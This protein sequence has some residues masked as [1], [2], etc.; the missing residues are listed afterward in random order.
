ML[1]WRRRIASIS[2]LVLATG[3]LSAAGFAVASPA[4]AVTCSGNGCNGVDPHASGCDANAI[5]LAS[6]RLIGSSGIDGGSIEMRYSTICGT[7]WIRISARFTDCSGEPCQNHASITRLSGPDGPS[8]SFSDDGRPAAGEPRQWSRMV[9]SAH[10][11]SCGTGYADVGLLL[12]FPNG[13]RG[14]QVCG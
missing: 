14:A 11:T 6:A 5:T 13:V 10:E 2:C 4:L 3:A 1:N 9:Y 12:T 7:Q 8:I